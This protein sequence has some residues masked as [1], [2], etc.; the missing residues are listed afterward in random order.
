[1]YDLVDALVAAGNRFR[2][3]PPGLGS[4]P[5]WLTA[6]NPVCH[7]EE[8]IDFTV[9][10][11]VPGQPA[12]LHIDE[13]NELIFCKQCWTAIDGPSHQPETAWDHPR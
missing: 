6:G 10:R 7:L 11:A 3:R 8:P 1:M 13:D 5:F 12:D 9:A 2:P 4:D